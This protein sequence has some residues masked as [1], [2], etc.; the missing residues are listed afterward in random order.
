[1]V[2]GAADEAATY[3]IPYSH[4]LQYD[5]ISD[6]YLVAVMNTDDL[7]MLGLNFFQN[8]YTV[9]DQENMQIGFA[10]SKEGRHPP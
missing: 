3:T 5:Y 6:T 1:M 10:Q 9:F 7:Y 8:Y 4:Y 2:M